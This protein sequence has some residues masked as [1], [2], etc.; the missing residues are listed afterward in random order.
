MPT[1]ERTTKG[2]ERCAT[3]PS[4]LTVGTCDV[5]GRPLC[6]QC[7]VPVRGR[8]LGAECLAEVLGKE[9]PATTP[10]RPWRRLRSPAD[11]VAGACLAVAV[12]ATLLPWTRFSTGSG[13]AGA[14]TF[15]I[16]WSMLAASA[17]V[18]GLAS[19]LAFGRRPSVTRTA[20][21]VAGTVV[22]VGSLLAA[23]NPPPFTKPALA[24]WIGLAAGAGAA[25]VGA[26]TRLRSIA[27]HV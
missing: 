1:E 16:R 15:D 7:A 8:V 27:P 9:V 12:L 2:A 24:P 19:W 17:S 26:Y 10:P 11:R 4:R 13:F 25:I 21:V 6:I 14:W 20:T 3:H 5:C 22:V 18:I 23:L